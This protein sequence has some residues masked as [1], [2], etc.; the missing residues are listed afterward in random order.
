[1]LSVFNLQFRGIMIIKC[2]IYD[3]RGTLRKK[4]NETNEKQITEVEVTNLL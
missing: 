2:R 3:V 4:A 1:M